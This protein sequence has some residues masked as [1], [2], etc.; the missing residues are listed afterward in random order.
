M[1]VGVI[2]RVGGWAKKIL[3]RMNL[4]SKLEYLSPSACTDLGETF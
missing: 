2:F 4:P 1:E 3:G